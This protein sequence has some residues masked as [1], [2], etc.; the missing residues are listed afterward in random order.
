[1]E[2]HNE[3]RRKP[4]IETSNLVDYVLFDQARNTLEKGKGHTLNLSQTGLL[5]Q[6]P[7]PL[8]GVFVMLM[9]IDL[10]GNDVKVEG[11]LIYTKRDESSGRYLSG[12]EFTGPR[13]KQV[14]AI[15]TFVKAYQ[16]R[17]HMQA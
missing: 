4:R 15:V 5:L 12:V 2:R 9:T 16:H 3:K 17:K 8:K 11:R 14:Q 10:N 6:T 7:V 13:D 1:M